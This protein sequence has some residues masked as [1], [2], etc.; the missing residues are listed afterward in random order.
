MSV[1]AVGVLQSVDAIVGYTTY[2]DL[3]RPLISEKPVIMSTGMKKETERVQAAI[4]IAREGKSCA[5]VSSGDPGVYAMAGLVFEICRDN[6]IPL[7]PLS[8]TRP[9]S[10]NGKAL[11]FEIVPGI[12]A[13]C[14]G[15]SLLGA[16]LMHDFAAISL[17]DLMTPWDRIEARLTAAAESDFVI[18]LYN[19]RSKKRRTHL[20]RA[21]QIIMRHREANTPVGIVRR[22]MRD[23][24]QVQIVPLGNL[25]K[26]E[27][28]MQTTVFIGNSATRTYAEYM[29]TPR[30]YADKYDLQDRLGTS[31]P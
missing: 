31:D 28:D 25:H 26:A 13:L 6:D 16:P 10:M 4:R 8:A 3:I 17:S 29:V 11:R 12:P 2:I 15:A 1:R 20:E 19:P 30:G 14:A 7:L 5:L 22:A 21:Q 24:E 18:V 27:V 23:G 9:K